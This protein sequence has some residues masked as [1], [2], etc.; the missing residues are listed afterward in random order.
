MYTHHCLYFCII[1]L[2]MEIKRAFKT[3]YH[4]RTVAALLR[5]ESADLSFRDHMV[6]YKLL[7]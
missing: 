4:A 3:K 5:D 1:M 7:S 6:R 2:L